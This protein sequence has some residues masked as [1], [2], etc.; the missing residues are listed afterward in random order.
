MIKQNTAAIKSGWEPIRL[1]IADREIPSDK[2]AAS[3]L[4]A[5]AAR[6]ILIRD[7]VFIWRFSGPLLS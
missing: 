5:Q 7:A 3:K 2:W 6:Y 1:Y 4:K